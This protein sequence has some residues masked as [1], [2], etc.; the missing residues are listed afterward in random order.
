MADFIAPK[1]F[2][3]D[4]WINVLDDQIRQS[5]D[6]VCQ[7]KKIFNYLVESDI[8]TLTIAKIED[9]FV[10]AVQ[11]KNFDGLKKYVEGE[12]PKLSSF[13]SDFLSSL[14]AKLILGRL[15]GM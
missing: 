3:L 15:E 13:I 7:W 10:S 8:S 14:C 12:N 1:D 9:K 4:D 6:P 5:I 2:A 11:K